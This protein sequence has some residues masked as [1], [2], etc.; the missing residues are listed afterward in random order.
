MGEVSSQSHQF[1]PKVKAQKQI[2]SKKFQVHFLVDNL[3]FKFSS[4]RATKKQ[5]SQVALKPS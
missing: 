2:F 1:Q 5:L 3:Q 4:K